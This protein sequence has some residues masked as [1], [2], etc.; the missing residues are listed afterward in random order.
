MIFYRI[1]FDDPQFRKGF[2]TT[3]R[4]GRKHHTNITK[5][6]EKT[7]ERV[8]LS[9]CETGTE[10]VIAFGTLRSIECLY[11]DQL[12]I[13]ECATNHVA[14]DKNSLKRAMENAYA[15]IITDNDELTMI[16]F[17]IMHENKDDDNDGGED[18][19]NTPPT[20][21]LLSV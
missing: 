16:G 10:N 12:S 19:I 3:L 15:K 20:P 11:W 6:L 9:L 18:I 4:L 8:V 17:D 13:T 14:R 7:A 5:I 2:N 1:D 21:S